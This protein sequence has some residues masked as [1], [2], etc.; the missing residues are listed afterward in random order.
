MHSFNFGKSQKLYQSCSIFYAEI[1]SITN[2]M[3]LNHYL[4]NK[5]KD[6]NEVKLMILDEI[7]SGFSNTTSRQIIFSNFEYEANKLVNEG[8]PFTYEKLQDIHLDMI[9]KYIGSDKPREALLKQPYVTGLAMPLRVSHFYVGN[10]YVYK[11]AIGQIAAIVISDRIMKGDKEALNNYYKFLKSG[12]S[13]SPMDT[14][15]LLGIDL[16][17]PEVWQEAKNIMSKYLE[18]FK[19]IVRN[20]TNA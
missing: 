15:A 14:I 6:D 16:S 3:L 18:E 9:D 8:S 17:K 13:K 12:S 5:Y 19:K 7:I 11:Y 10:F 1:A 2:E 20:K 4:L